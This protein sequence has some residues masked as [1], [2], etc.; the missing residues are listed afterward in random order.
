MAAVLLVISGIFGL[1]VY[2]AYS[3]QLARDNPPD[4]TSGL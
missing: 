3:K 1:V 2:V 4:T